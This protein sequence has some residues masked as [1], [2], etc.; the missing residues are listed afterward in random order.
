MPVIIKCEAVIRN[1]LL[2]T[3]QAHLSVAVKS[4]RQTGEINPKRSDID[5]LEK[6]SQKC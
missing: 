5:V 3:L 1:G 6:H 4:V 2:H